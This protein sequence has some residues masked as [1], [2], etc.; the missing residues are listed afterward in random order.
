MSFDACCRHFQK[1]CKNY[2]LKSATLHKIVI[3]LGPLAQQA[4]MLPLDH[5]TQQRK[6][7]ITNN[8]H[9]K[10]AKK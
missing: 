5:G 3:L 9:K 6:T 2:H 8:S 10:K 7:N 1:S 4:S